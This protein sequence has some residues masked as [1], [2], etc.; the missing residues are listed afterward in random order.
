MQVLFNNWS[1]AIKAP[2]RHCAPNIEKISE[3][4]TARGGGGGGG[5]GKT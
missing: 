2:E 4:V 3:V 1:G 5:G